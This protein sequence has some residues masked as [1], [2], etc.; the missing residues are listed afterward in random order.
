MVS[1]VP[2]SSKYSRTRLS[3]NSRLL[4]DT[5]AKPPLIRYRFNII[6]LAQ[7]KLF[8]NS[9][10]SIATAEVDVSV[11]KRNVPKVQ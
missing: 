1:F 4:Y 9:D 6:H 2:F 10:D 3:G 7:A 8:M 11:P 5:Q